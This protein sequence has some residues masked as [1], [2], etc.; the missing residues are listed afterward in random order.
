VE[1]DHV[2][3]KACEYIGGPDAKK[4]VDKGTVFGVITTGKIRKPAKERFDA[5]NI[6]YAENVPEDEIRNYKNKGNN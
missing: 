3:I 6:D 2:E 4:I 5:A 1:P